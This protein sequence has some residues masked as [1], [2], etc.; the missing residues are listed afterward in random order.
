M[1][2]KKRCKAFFL[3]AKFETVAVNPSM[4]MKV[5]TH[6][7]T[8]HEGMKEFDGKKKRICIKFLLEWCLGTKQ[9]PKQLA[10]SS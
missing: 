2:N 5:L 8:H 3:Q 10:I 6:C 1:S 9:F 7:Y 4:L